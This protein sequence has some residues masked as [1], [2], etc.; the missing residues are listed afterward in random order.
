MFCLFWRLEWIFC[1]FS[2]FSF[3]FPFLDPFKLLH[4]LNQSL[5]TD[6]KEFEDTILNQ[7]KRNHPFLHCHLAQLFLFL[8]NLLKPYLKEL[9][10]PQT[11]SRVIQPF[12]SPCEIWFYHV[13]FKFEFSSF[14]SHGSGF[15]IWFPL[16]TDM[17]VVVTMEGSLLIGQSRGSCQTFWHL[18]LWLCF[19]FNRFF[20]F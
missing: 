19:I 16:L 17:F 3:I 4:S 12:L 10:K 8:S 1:F 15:I 11:I 6:S 20:S 13:P 18:L 7:C 14:S 5:I 9:L 2:I